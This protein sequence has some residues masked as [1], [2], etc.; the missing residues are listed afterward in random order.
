MTDIL[1]DIFPQLFDKTRE[2]SGIGVWHV[3]LTKGVVFWDKQT[4]IIHQVPDNYKPELAT[5]INFY[6]EGENRDKIAALCNNIIEKGESF[7]DEFEL[8]T[9][10]NNCIW[11]RSIGMPQ[12]K[13]DEVVGFYGTFQDITKKKNEVAELLSLKERTQL[14]A[15]AGSVGVWDWD[16]EANV[17]VWDEQMFK[18]Y[19]VARDEF[20][21][22]Y[23]AWQ[24]GLHPDD[25]EK[26]KMDVDAALQNK[27]EFDTTFRIVWPSGDIRF[28]RGLGKVFWDAEGKPIR[29]IGMNWD[30]T[31]EVERE[32]KINDLVEKFKLAQYVSNYGIW[33]WDLINDELI[34]D[35]NQFKLYNATDAEISENL[36]KQFWNEHIHPEDRENAIKDTEEAI[37]GKSEF[38]SEFRIVCTDQV[39]K[40]IRA[41]GHVVRNEKDEPIYMMGVNWDVTEDVKMNA[42]LKLQNEDLTTLSHKL[43][44]SNDQLEEFGYIVSHDL[45]TPVNNMANYAKMLKEQCKEIAS[46]DGLSMITGIENQAAKMSKLIDDLLIFSKVGNVKLVKDEV[47]LKDIVFQAVNL[48]EYEDRSDIKIT[49][50][51]LGSYSFDLVRMQEVF[52]NLLTNAVKYNNSEIKEI[53]IWEEDKKIM[54]QDNGIGIDKKNTSKVFEFFQRLHPER[55][56]GGGTGAGMAIVK[57]I[58]DRHHIDITIKS[59]LGAGTT[60]VMDFS[61]V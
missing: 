51:E 50:G 9:G 30:V 49:V 60:F 44:L 1:N 54:V 24:S 61:K 41:R 31:V 35:Q 3:D 4:K 58:L 45:K 39:I 28:I 53:N 47:P 36:P 55:K 10:E 46:Q 59:E 57:R 37:V 22:A 29:M 16:I 40:H 34:W 42:A 27:K 6:K 48:L 20:A 56:Y 11:V 7:D 12:F 52:N 32:N 43:K 38:A 13:N 25:Q 5:G 14:A 15:R 33:E 19:G 26:G 18:I 2:I 17:L 21:G 8:I 23:E